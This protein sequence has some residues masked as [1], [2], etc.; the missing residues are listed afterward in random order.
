LNPSPPLW[1]VLWQNKFRFEPVWEPTLIFSNSLS[2]FLISFDF[3]KK[4][5]QSTLS[6][7]FFQ[8]CIAWVQTPP[9]CVEAQ[10]TNH[11]ATRTLWGERPVS[12]IYCS[13]AVHITFSTFRRNGQRGNALPWKVVRDKVVQ[14]EFLY[15]PYFKEILRA[16]GWRDSAKNV[17]KSHFLANFQTPV[18]KSG[19]AVSKK[20]PDKRWSVTKTESICIIGTIHT[21]KSS[22]RRRRSTLVL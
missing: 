21:E 5:H 6:I 12:G 16:T 19:A 11:L 1:L 22:S 7:L 18:R 15:L 8:K 10:H 20:C 17:R 3:A 2:F 9:A 14:W 4:E 13:P